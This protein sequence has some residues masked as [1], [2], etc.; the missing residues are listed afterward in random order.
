MAKLREIIKQIFHEFHS[1]VATP[2]RVEIFNRMA[3]NV[4][5]F[6]LRLEDMT[7]EAHKYQ[8]EVTK[9][10]NELTELELNMTKRTQAL[11]LKRNDLVEGYW[12]Q[13]KAVGE[14]AAL[15]K[16]KLGELATLSSKALKVDSFFSKRSQTWTLFSEDL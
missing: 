12:A 9:L 7:H 8:R 11:K 3:M 16:Q 6:S 4:A 1:T 2:K 10:S 15:D 14:L 5:C 13:K